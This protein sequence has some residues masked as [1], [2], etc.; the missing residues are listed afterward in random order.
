MKNPKQN[1][2]IEA[3]KARLK[4]QLIPEG[5]IPN[6][7]V[8]KQSDLIDANATLQFAK[9]QKRPVRYARPG[10][11]QYTIELSQKEP[12]KEIP[13]NGLLNTKEAA[14]IL[15]IK[16]PNLIVLRRSGKINGELIGSRYYFTT[17]EVERVKIQRAI[18]KL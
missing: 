5:N 17:Q 10:E 7:R 15:N 13:D 12:K 18:D 3:I 9:S 6:S 8:A 16:T 4:Q 2:A 1:P 11:C 14:E